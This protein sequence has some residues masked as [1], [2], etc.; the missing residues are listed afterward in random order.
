MTQPIGK[1]DPSVVHTSKAL[2]D[3]DSE[4]V[5]HFRQ[6]GSEECCKF[7]SWVRE[8]MAGGKNSV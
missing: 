5:K 6:F 1:L 4:N 7:V 2:Q 8:T 3:I